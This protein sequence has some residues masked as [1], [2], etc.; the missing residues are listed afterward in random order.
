MTAQHRSG[1]LGTF[2]DLTCRLV[3]VPS[4][5]YNLQA[6]MKALDTVLSFLDN[7]I[8]RGAYVASM[9]K[10]QAEDPGDTSPEAVSLHV[11]PQASAGGPTILLLGHVDVV[12]PTHEDQFEPRLESGR[13]YGRGAGDMKGGVAIAAALFAEFSR[14]R[15]VELLLTSDE[16]QGGMLGAG[17]LARTLQPDFVIALEPTDLTLRLREKGGVLVNVQATG[18]GGHASRPWLAENAVELLFDV[19]RR[20]R[21]TYP[22]TDQEE[23]VDTMNVGAICGGNVCWDEASGFRLGLGNA[24]ASSAGMCLDFRLTEQSSID[25]ARRAVSIAIDEAE[26][27]LAARLLRRR[28][29]P[30][31]YTITASAPRVTVD[32]LVTDAD[33]PLVRK[34][35]ESTE[36]VLERPAEFGAGSG[37]SD[38]RF[39]SA[40]G[41]PSVVFGPKSV[42]HHGADEY[43]EIESLSEA[44]AALARFLGDLA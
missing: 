32:H 17:R 33:H 15:N 26:S 3:R 31:D 34:L 12:A 28:G 16:E 18:P 4:V 44:H 19:L 23:W 20:L 39:F 10:G 25:D 37:A 11:R 24:I 40:R 7:A 8:G 5:A 29:S 14:E 38:A 42:N 13:L 27:D 35:A 36:A 41:V 9:T 30:T 22:V 43:L 6:R 1:L 21:Q 2:I